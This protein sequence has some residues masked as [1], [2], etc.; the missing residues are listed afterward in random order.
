MNESAI[1]ISAINAP[2][3][4]CEKRRLGCHGRCKAYKAFRD[5]LDAINERR[6]LLSDA[7]ETIRT[8]EFEAARRLEKRR[9]RR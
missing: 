9:R 5:E 3:K 1:L 6:R 4:N 2:C 8:M 7:D